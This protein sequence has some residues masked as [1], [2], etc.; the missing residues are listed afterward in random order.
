MTKDDTV[1]LDVC[2]F[3]KNTYRIQSAHHQNGQGGGLALI[4]RS[5]SDVKPVA[6]GQTRSFKY[7]TWLIV[8]KKKN[9]TVTGI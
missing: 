9:I 2:D 8:I 5:T 1:W 3:N 4:H 7:T 6:R